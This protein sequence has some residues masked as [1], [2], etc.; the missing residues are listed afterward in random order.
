MP[1]RFSTGGLASSMPIGGGR[2]M[3]QAIEIFQNHPGFGV[4]MRN[5]YE[6]AIADKRYNEMI[7]KHLLIYFINI[8]IL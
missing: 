6:Q 8:N 3:I 1:D 5:N 4:K 2:N 7:V